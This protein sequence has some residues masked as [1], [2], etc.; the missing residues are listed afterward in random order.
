[1]KSFEERLD[2]SYVLTE[3]EGGREGEEGRRCVSTWN[4]E[5]INAKKRVAK[6]SKGGR[7]GM[8]KTGGRKGE[9]GWG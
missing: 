7:E 9:R 6:C 4:R 1:M 8:R 5:M 2:E 3:I